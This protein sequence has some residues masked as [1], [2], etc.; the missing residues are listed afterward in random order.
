MEHIEYYDKYIKYKHKYISSKLKKSS[1]KGGG[2]YKCEPKNKFKD[3]C[4]EDE[5]GKYKNKESCINDCEQ[6]YI[7]NQ[8]S[9]SEIRKETEK[10]YLLIKDVIQNEKIS[11][12]IKGGN[13]LGLCV[14]KM[15]YDKF[16]NNDVMFEKSFN[17]FLE[18]KLIKDWDFAGYTK[19]AITEDYRNKLDKIAAKYKFVPR[20]KTFILY[21]TK[22]PILTDK[23]ALFE[24]STLDSDAYSKLEL[25]MTTMK[26]RVT[27][28]NLKYIFMFAKSFY[29]YDTKSEQIDF[30]VIKRMLSKI[31]III[32]PH[33]NGLYDP[34]KDFDKG[35]LNNELIDY[36]KI[37][38]DN[39]LRITQFLATHFE[40]PFRM[41]YRLPEKNIP[42]NTKIKK[43]LE[44]YLNIQKM[45][46][47]LMETNKIE[48][49]I[50]RFFDEM[51]EKIYDI[52]I[53]EYN[54]TE[55]ITTAISNVSQ[56][57]SGVNFN[58]TQIEYDNYSQNSK[59]YLHKLF[60]KCFE[61]IG[62]DNIKMLDEKDRFVVFFKFLAKKIY[63][64]NAKS[65]KNKSD[66][67]NQSDSSDSSDSSNNADQNDKNKK[68]NKK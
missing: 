39:N 5:N 12:Y 32:H 51:P 53:T 4:I 42:K 22:Y 3:I 10:F 63:E 48:S 56:F 15:I 30:D 13:V 54:R 62:Y 16:K 21:Q 67:S 6:K 65:D 44:T 9:T 45:P 11:V 55:N 1:I 40:D 58:R 68:N 43:F 24:I 46:S 34:G 35:G 31:N 57:L 47:W 23:K 66:Q 2:K 38:S 50:D 19:F 60:G 14:L 17:N 52:Y 33:R 29:H 27:P 8:L 28:H 36:I 37:F 61:T 64:P 41:L 26:I 7:S 18:L 25:P 59:I 49:L 20:A